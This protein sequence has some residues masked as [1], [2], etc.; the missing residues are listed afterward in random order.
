MMDI[1]SVYSAL[2]S[3]ENASRAISLGRS[4]EARVVRQPPITS[5]PRWWIW[6]IEFFF[7]SLLLT[8]GALSPSLAFNV[9]K[10]GGVDGNSW[11][12]ALSFEPGTYVVLDE[13]G[14]HMDTHP[15]ASIINYE[16][17]EDTLNS[18][19]DSTGGQWIGPVFVPPDL[20]LAQDGVRT[21][22]KRGISDNLFSS[23]NCHSVT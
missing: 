21:R 19:V 18:I 6:S 12:T 15:V 13:S 9:Y 11:S 17:W 16:S 2:D 7:C 23:A 8:I 20:N 4:P 1:R 22:I 10:L 14:A 5:T 3:F